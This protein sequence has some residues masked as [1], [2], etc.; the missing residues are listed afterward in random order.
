MTFTR[1][2]RQEAV[3]HFV[4]VLCDEPA[5]G[6]L[7]KSLAH[8]DYADM[9]DIALITEDDIKDL[10]YYDSGTLTPLAGPLQSLVWIFRMYFEHRC[11]QGD[12]I[13]EKFT[14]KRTVR[15]LVHSI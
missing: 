4:T 2:Q 7:A 14:S 15:R 8:C 12:P 3:A 10:A 11:K 13:S 5:D 1:L 9:Q 6:A